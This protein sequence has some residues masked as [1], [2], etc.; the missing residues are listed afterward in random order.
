MFLRIKAY[1]VALQALLD[2]VSASSPPSDATGGQLSELFGEHVAGEA[3]AQAGQ[4]QRNAKGE[5]RIFSGRYVDIILISFYI[6]FRF[7]SANI[8]LWFCA[9]SF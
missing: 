7:C 6:L 9:V 8:M 5:V 3:L 1:R 2:T 4:V